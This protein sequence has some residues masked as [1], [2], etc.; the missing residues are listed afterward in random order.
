M[1]FSQ[2]SDTDIKIQ[3]KGKT[4]RIDIDLENNHLL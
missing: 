3:G 4:I 1:F 2:F